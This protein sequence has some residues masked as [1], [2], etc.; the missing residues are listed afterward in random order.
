VWDLAAV[1]N[2]VTVVGLPFAVVALLVGV[3]QLNL[4]G[5]A[6]SASVLVPLHE[7]FRQAWLRFL[8]AEEDDERTHLFND[9]FNLL[10]LGCAIWND[11]LLKGNSG[12]LLFAYLRHALATIQSSPDASARME[13]SLHNEHTYAN[14]VAFMDKHS[15]QITTAR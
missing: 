2:L 9:I 3:N 10:E 4:A 8:E 14:I 13:D 7:S 1:A 12:E 11:G 6:T 5:K 15:D